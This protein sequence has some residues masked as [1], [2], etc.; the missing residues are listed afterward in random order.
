MSDNETQNETSPLSIS[1]SL[2]AKFFPEPLS[3][4][5]APPSLA[6]APSSSA[7]GCEPFRVKTPPPPR[8]NQH[9]YGL[10]KFLTADDDDVVSTS[11]SPP[12]KPSTDTSALNMSPLT[13]PPSIAAHYS[14]YIPLPP[15]A[16]YSPQSIISHD[17]DDDDNDE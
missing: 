9:R 13:L 2:Y 14:I 15:E 11:P 17:D 5:S 8:P 1:S 12:L 10:H 6:L 16:F 4:S 7:S 3:Q